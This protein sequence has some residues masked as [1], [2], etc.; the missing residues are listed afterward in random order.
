MLD[1]Q[2]LTTKTKCY[3]VWQFT[4]LSPPPCT[5]C[6]GTYTEKRKGSWHI[7]GWRPALLPTGR[8]KGKPPRSV[9]QSLGPSNISADKA[10]KNGQCCFLT[11]C[12]GD[13]EMSASSLLGAALPQPSKL[14]AQHFKPLCLLSQPPVKVGTCYEGRLW[15]GVA[16]TFLLVLSIIYWQWRELVDEHLSCNWGTGF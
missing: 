2:D 1:R 6:C 7:P 3:E 4:W 5:S 14:H 15:R 13:L 11:I 10:S 9:P 8:V 12:Q 16:D